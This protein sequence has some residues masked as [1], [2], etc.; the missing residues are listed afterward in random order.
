[1]ENE[2]WKD[3]IGFEGL[4]QISNMGR[5]KSFHSPKE[6]ILKLHENSIGYLRI[7]LH[8]NCNSKH[9]RISRLV[10]IHFIPNPL[11]L[12]QV[13]HKNLN[14]KDNRVVNLEWCTPRQN[15]LHA[16]KHHKYWNKNKYWAINANKNYPVIGFRISAEDNKFL[17]DLAFNNCEK[18]SV[19]V[20]NIILKH[21][22]EKRSNK[23]QKKQLSK[24]KRLLSY[25]ITSLM[26]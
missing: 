18:R 14:K 24:R 10:A 1:M 25:R 19:Y 26:K 17:N 2:I 6:K 23:C 20:K 9:E 21:L 16:R 11:N 12:P 5:V 15:T 13:N 22:N 7:G 3:I 4:Y 8:K